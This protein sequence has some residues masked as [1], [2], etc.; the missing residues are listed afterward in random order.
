MKLRGSIPLNVDQTMYNIR[1]YIAYKNT[2]QT[3]ILTQV[4]YYKIKTTMN[5]NALCSTFIKSMPAI[6]KHVKFL[7][8]NLIKIHHH[9][10]YITLVKEIG[11]GN[12]LKWPQVETFHYAN[13]PNQ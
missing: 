3:C 13:G 11:K 2:M 1:D 6:N 4:Q 12:L 8:R 5:K 7:R 10:R 9:Q